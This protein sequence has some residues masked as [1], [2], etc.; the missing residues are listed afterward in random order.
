MLSWRNAAAKL[1]I[2]AGRLPKTGIFLKKTSD[3]SN[4]SI[5]LQQNTDIPGEIRPGLC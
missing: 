2:P 3:I 4:Y 1:P 5:F